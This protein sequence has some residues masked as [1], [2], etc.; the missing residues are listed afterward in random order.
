MAAD[1]CG[2]DSGRV[3]HPE[4]V[5]AL[6]RRL[7][8]DSRAPLAVGLSGGSD[9]LALLLLVLE[10]ARPIGRRVLALT[11]DHGLNPQS[12]RWTAD[13]GAVAQASG[14]DWR[15]LDWSG[16]KPTSGLPAAA[17]RARHA[18]LA[19][20]A[21]ALGARV[22]LLGH[23]A[24]DVAESELIRRET[25]THGTSR[26][27]A[28]SPVWPEGRGVFLLR[29]LLAMRR[30][31]LR[32]E[33]KAGGFGW[34]DDPANADLR[35]AR[36]R[37]RLAL[38]A[39]LGSPV[40]SEAGC[41]AVVAQKV[42]AD[43][44]GV[45]TLPFDALAMYSNAVLARAI[46]CASGRETPPSG[47][48]LSKRMTSIANGSSG[49][50]GGARTAVGERGVTVCRELGRRPPAPTPL[51]PGEPG[52][53]DGRF[54]LMADVHGWRAATLAGHAARLPREDRHRLARVPAIARP[55]LP[56]LLDAAGS[57]R[58]PR[59]FGEGPGVAR[60][61]VYDR[62]VA[63]FGLIDSER[64]LAR[65]LRELALHGA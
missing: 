29:P 30:A 19:N 56:V 20:A 27:W 8:R 63:A 47:S 34:L 1:G 57:A 31:A 51:I 45:V 10:W 62:L 61:L 24:D 18:L 17:R 16:P 15:A 39:S 46:T 50:L 4:A 9:S 52:V 58:L 23:T 53:F 48:A 7:D 55:A 44:T 38:G 32:A 28:P 33:L 49:T 11:V 12:A 59:P 43:P 13:A 14:A 2:L 21:R 3:A 64:T 22:L 5:A 54:E 41:S 37:A 60:E 40:H 36:A 26:E 65:D 42:H 6:D 35:F 25:P